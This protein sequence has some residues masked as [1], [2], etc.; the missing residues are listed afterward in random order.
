MFALGYQV[1]RLDH[2]AVVTTDHTACT[3][4]A[5]VEDPAAVQPGSGQRAANRARF[6]VR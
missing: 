1:S 4:L 2:A 6:E 3:L 5:R